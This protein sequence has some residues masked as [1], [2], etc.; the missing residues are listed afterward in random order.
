MR[1]YIKINARRNSINLKVLLSQENTYCVLSSIGTSHAPLLF[2]SAFLCAS[3]FSL[4]SDFHCYA[5]GHLLFLSHAL[6]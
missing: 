5:D 1:Q 4:H 2:Q 3:Q 6:A